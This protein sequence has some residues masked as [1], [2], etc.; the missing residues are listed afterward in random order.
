M[1]KEKFVER[2]NVILYE[3]CGCNKKEAIEVLEECLKQTKACKDFPRDRPGRT[4]LRL[5]FVEKWAKF[6]AEHPDEEWSKLQADL[7]NSQLENS[8]QIKLTKE[9][10]D[11]IKD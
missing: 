1:D 2:I 9:Q 3:T 5:D 4:K 11:Y 6:V 7:I 10:V 8:K